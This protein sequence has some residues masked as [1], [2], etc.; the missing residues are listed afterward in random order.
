MPP[1][2]SVVVPVHNA[3]PHLPALTEFHELNLRTYV[4]GGGVP[5]LW[6]FSLDAASWPAAA[7]A[8]VTL[9]LPYFHARMERSAPGGAHQYRSDRRA[10][11]SR[12]NQIS[13]SSPT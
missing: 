5:G 1:R 11:G 6:F 10:P 3:L 8:R 12:S 13:T 7:I 2:V 4:R 9:G